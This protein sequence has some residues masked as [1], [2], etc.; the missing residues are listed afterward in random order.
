[1]AAS[2]VITT[3]APNGLNWAVVLFYCTGCA[4]IAKIT[5]ITSN[6][7]KIL[8]KYFFTWHHPFLFV[9]NTMN[10]CLERN[11]AVNRPYVSISAFYNC[12]FCSRKGVSPR[13]IFRTCSFTAANIIPQYDNFFKLKIGYTNAG[14]KNGQSCHFSIRFKFHHVSRTLNLRKRANARPP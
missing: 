3:T 1:M 4:K 9:L 2:G 14:T 6:A 7:T 13:G 11:E 8:K 5:I 12:A 10:K